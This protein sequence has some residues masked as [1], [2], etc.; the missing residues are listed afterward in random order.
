MPGYQSTIPAALAGLM[1]T[2]T[3]WPDLEGVEVRD[4]PKVT[5]SKALE[6]IGVGWTG[7]K[8][9]RTGAYPENVSPMAEVTTTVDTL[10]LTIAFETYPI[11]NVLAVLNGGR[12]IEPAR[13]RAYALLS[14]CGAAIAAD[15]KLGGAVGMAYL[16]NHSMTQEQTQRGALVTIAFEVNCQAWT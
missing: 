11:R 10:S 15:K 4:G 8:M 1:A 14:A 16:G 3:A 12:D 7:E 2:L 5:E 9:A 13:T 6:V